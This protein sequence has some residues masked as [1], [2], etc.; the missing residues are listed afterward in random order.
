M[1]GGTGDISINFH[2]YIFGCS[3]ETLAC[4]N[5]DS[6]YQYVRIYNRLLVIVTVALIPHNK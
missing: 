3:N 5:F 1:Y 4:N 6:F 2:H